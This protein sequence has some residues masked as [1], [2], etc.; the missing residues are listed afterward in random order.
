MKKYETFDHTADIGIRIFGKSH[1]D[2]FANAAYALFDLL[3]DLK[4][5]EEKISK[6]ISLTGDDPEDLLIR[7]LNELLFFWST[8][9][10]LFKRFSFSRLD[11]TVLR[12]KAYGE[13]FDPMRHRIKL[14]IKAATYHQV[15]IRQNDDGWEGKV[16]LDV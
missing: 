5:A 3:T 7:W 11:P 13:I 16:I 15:E 12:G 10:Y 4:K 14:E 9:G 1:E 2:L 8:Q 6:N